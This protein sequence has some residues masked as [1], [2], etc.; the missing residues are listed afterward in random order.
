M[1]QGAQRVPA[2]LASG[3][4]AV[5]LSAEDARER[6]RRRFWAYAAA[7]GAAWGALEITVGSFLHSLQMPFTGVL[8]ASVGAAILVAQRQ[9]LPVRGLTLATGLVAAAC[10]SLSPGGVILGPMVGISTEALLV[11]LA[12]FLAPRAVAGAAVGGALA[13]L[14][15]LSQK[16]LGQVL[17]YGGDML[18]LYVAALRRVASWVGLERGVAVRALV[19]ILVIFSVVGATGGVLGWRAGRACH[20]RLA[21]ERTS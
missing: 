16:L 21:A 3:P 8:L 14:W 20:R 7:F 9:V 10:K 13:A 6:A 2:P 4:G 18:A 19:T 17:F 11:E 12:L 1:L 5:P 15:A